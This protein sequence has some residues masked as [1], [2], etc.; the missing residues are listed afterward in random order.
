[1]SKTF[2]MIEARCPD[3]NALEIKKMYTTKT[4]Y[5]KRG[6]SSVNLFKKVYNVTVTTYTACKEK[7]VKHLCD[8]A[9]NN[10]RKQNDSV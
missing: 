5:E 3:T 8:K 4:N 6:K 10:K 9:T 1:M 7:T 2:V